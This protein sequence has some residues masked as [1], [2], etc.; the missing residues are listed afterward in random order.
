MGW[1]GLVAPR[2]EYRLRPKMQKIC[3]VCGKSFES[4]YKAKTCSS[5]CSKRS[6]Y[7]YQRYTWTYGLSL[8]DYNQMFK[9]QNGCCAI[10][11][12]HQSE[13]KTKLNVDHNHLTGEIRKLLC[14]QC[15]QA[16]GLVKENKDTLKRMLEYVS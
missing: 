3:T 4:A 15:N 11:L 12:K 14:N 9:E 1:R 5:V 10:C 2:P 8:N 16:L 13:L 6:H 7:F